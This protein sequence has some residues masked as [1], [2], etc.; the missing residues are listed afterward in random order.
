M[1]AP[2]FLVE[3]PL[4]LRSLG[5][6]GNPE[7]SGGLAEWSIAP[8]L[9]SIFLASIVSLEKRNPAKRGNAQ[10]IIFR[11]SG[12]VAERLKATL[13]KSVIRRT[14][15]VSSNLT[16]TALSRNKYG[17]FVLSLSKDLRF[18]R[19]NAVYGEPVS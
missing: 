1:N 7:Y 2:N 19:E 13:L 15:I 14:R 8:H 18:V 6:A 9:L 4:A 5:E 16:P 10:I 17:I 11:Q 3:Y 12:G